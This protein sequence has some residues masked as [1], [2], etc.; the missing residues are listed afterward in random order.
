M[1]DKQL[2]RTSMAVG[3]AMGLCLAVYAPHGFAVGGL[4]AS[5][6]LAAWSIWSNE[7]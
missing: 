2:M 6:G 4:I 7:Q 5:V 3:Y 1:S